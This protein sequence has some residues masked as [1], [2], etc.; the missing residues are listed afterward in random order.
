MI[1]MRHF[2][3]KTDFFLLRKKLSVCSEHDVPCPPISD[4]AEL[5]SPVSEAV[6]EN[7]LSDM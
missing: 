4:T 3:S 1:T 6:M 2:T 5:R 7:H